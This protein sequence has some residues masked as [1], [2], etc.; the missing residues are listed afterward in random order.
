VAEG[1][2]TVAVA[3]VEDIVAEDIVEE[4]TAADI[5]ADMGAA[6]A[7]I[8]GIGETDTTAH[9]DRMAGMEEDGRQDMVR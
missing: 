4:D 3:E 5:V 6:T 7:D 9:E 8:V 2:A 1:V